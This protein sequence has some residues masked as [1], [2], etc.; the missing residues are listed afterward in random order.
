MTMCV[1][2]ASLSPFPCNPC[3]LHQER[4]RDKQQHEANARQ[5][6]E[7]TSE[8]EV[9]RIFCRRRKNEIQCQTPNQ[10]DCTDNCHTNPD[11]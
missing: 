5:P 9:R 6:G 10:N 2:S 3:A 1:S 7:Q 11:G 8:K 4:Q